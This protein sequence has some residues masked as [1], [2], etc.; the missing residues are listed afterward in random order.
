MALSP[1]KMSS[2]PV[3][4]SFDLAASRC[5]DLTPLVYQRLFDKHPET[6][7]MFR[8]NGGAW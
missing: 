7:A 5:A 2:N 3:E 6:R 4:L 8:S 1:M